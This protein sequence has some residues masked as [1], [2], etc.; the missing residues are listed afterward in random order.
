[1]TATPNIFD[2]LA[3]VTPEP[4][5][6]RLDRSTLERYR[7]CPFRGAA[8]ELKL[9]DTGS[10][11]ADSGNEAHDAFAALVYD[12]IAS[13]G[14]A[15]IGELVETSLVRAAG[16]RRT[17]LQPDVLDAVRA[18][19]YRIARDI[20]YRPDGQ[21]RNP[22]D[23]LRF[24]GGKTLDEEKAKKL[25]RPLK[26][27]EMRTGQIAYDIVPGAPGRAAVRLTC[28]LDLLTAGDA[29]DEL[30]LTDWKTGRTTWTPP[31]VRES[32][33]FR[34]YSMVIMQVYPDC[35]RVWVRV[36]SPRTGVT[37]W[38][39]FTRRDAEDTAAQCLAIVVNR[40][41]ALA[42]PEEAACWCNNEKLARCP[43]L[44][45]C[46]KAK[47]AAPMLAAD[48]E[49]FLE[50]FALHS[51]RVDADAKLLAAYVREHGPLRS[52]GWEFGPTKPS[53]KARPVGLREV[54]EAEADV[55]GGNGD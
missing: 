46:L 40:R 29:R 7:D 21:H 22:N 45:L 26:P 12:Y 4:P 38:V 48:P 17:D 6:L 8:C 30:C 42:K 36:W 5:A 41:E 14:Q 32:F 44:K 33:Q 54:K 35:Q 19:V 55:P 31:Q 15:T 3:N 24:Q 11:P 16:T 47:A 23:I 28:E 53:T 27:D 13:D 49:S 25:G 52:G 20:Y 18:G 51:A 43:A 10:D 1:M 39:E 37:G 2:E 34:F 9:V 50:Y